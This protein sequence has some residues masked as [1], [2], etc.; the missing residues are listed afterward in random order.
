MPEEN[1][2]PLVVKCD[3]SAPNELGVVSKQGGKHAANTVSQPCVKVVENNLGLMRT[4]LSCSLNLCRKL[5][6]A[7]FKM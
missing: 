6:I 5:E 1:E 7:E 3:D 2:V 4:H